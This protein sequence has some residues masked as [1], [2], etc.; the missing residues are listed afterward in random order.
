[1]RRERI[2]ADQAFFAERLSGRAA[3]R[4][5]SLARARA[6][7][8]HLGID[9]AAWQARAGRVITVVGSKGKGTA[10]TFASATLSGAG[11]RVG[12]LTSPGLRSNRERIRVDGRAIS[13]GAYTDLVSEVS[14]TLARVAADL[15]ADGYL[16]PTGLFTLAALR[17]FE[18]RQ[19]EA[20]VLE[21]GMGG[22]SDEVSLV[23]AAVV[24]ISAIFD[25]HLGTLGDSVAAIAAEKAA[26]IT[27]A[28]RT[29]V[30]AVQSDPAV[31]AEIAAAVSAHGCEFHAVGVAGPAAVTAA[32][33]VPGLGSVS[34]RL[35]VAAGLALLELGGHPAPGNEALTAALESV[36][37]PGRLSRHHRPGQDWIVDC[38]TNPAAITT[39][40]DHATATLGPPSAVLVYIPAT[41]D[42]A[43]VLW[44]LDGQPVV[45]VGGGPPAGVPGDRASMRLEEIDL[46][47]LGPR[48]LAVGPVY[49]AGELLAILDVDCECSFRP[50]PRTGEGDVPREGE[51]TRT[52]A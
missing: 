18:D 4:R 41:R 32:E 12:T 21:A 46:D 44:A 8:P 27:G 39:A 52:P 49:F 47:R 15:P 33:G 31:E 26:V 45:R 42:A 2:D 3:G 40:V 37:L 11:L 10:A 35:G 20:V 17:H 7:A 22:S 29:V 28:T 43:P 30:A 48:V 13:P 14:A 50:V 23:G 36:R 34:A 24:A 6:F 19:C 5:R 38:A 9:L 25:E 1:M 16:S 51:C